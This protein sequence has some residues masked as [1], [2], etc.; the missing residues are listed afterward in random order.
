MSKKVC[1][2]CKYF[3]KGDKCPICKGEDFET[4]WKGRIYIVDAKKS[5]IAEKIDTDVKGEYALRI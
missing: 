4:S 2:K 5:K 3:V 1:K